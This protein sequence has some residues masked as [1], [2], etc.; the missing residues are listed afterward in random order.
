MITKE[1]LAEKLNGRTYLN[2][3]TEEEEQ[4]AK[5][6]ELVVVFGQSDDL[7]ELRGAIDDEL[8]MYDGGT[9]YLTKEGVLK[10]ECEDSDCPYFQKL[11]EDATQI[12]AVFGD[13]SPSLGV[14]GYSWSF[15]A[16]DIPDA[17]TFDIL[18]SD[19]EKYCRGF[20]FAME[21]LK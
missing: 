14:Q 3:M 2:E 15:R 7:V 6:S 17:A 21:D 10:N 18:D 16:V 11:L 9:I 12:L 20:I 5:E 19:G 4:E 8:D 1:E 13:D